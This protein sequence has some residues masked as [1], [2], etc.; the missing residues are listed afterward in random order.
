MPLVTRRAVATQGNEPHPHSFPLPLYLGTAPQH[1]P[2]TSSGLHQTPHGFSLSRQK[3]PLNSRKP[4]LAP[5][6]APHPPATSHGSSA[7]RCVHMFKSSADDRTGRQGCWLA[8]YSEQHRN[9]V[10]S[11]SSTLRPS[12]QA[13]SLS[14]LQRREEGLG[15]VPRKLVLRKGCGE[16]GLLGGDSGEPQWGVRKTDRK[17]ESHRGCEGAEQS[18]GQ[19]RQ[20]LTRSSG[21]RWGQ[22]QNCPLTK[23]KG[24]GVFIHPRV[25]PRN[26]YSSALPSCPTGQGAVPQ[27]EGGRCWPPETIHPTT[28]PEIV[29]LGRRAWGW[30]LTASLHCPVF[31]LLRLLAS[32]TITI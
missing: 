12:G 15:W 31:P 3:S 11:I 25:V 26:N 22:P 2:S 28:T 32:G 17:R 23:A 8:K 13:L 10:R 19:L 5:E 29:A 24:A 30:V 1:C 21:R 27:P 6:S 18:C 7:G 4:H 16:R 20:S 14:A 9:N